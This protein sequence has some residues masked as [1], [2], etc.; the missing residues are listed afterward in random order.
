MIARLKTWFW[1]G[2]WSPLLELLL[3]AALGISLAHWTWVALT[4]RAVAA[5]ALG[6]HLDAQRAAPTVK[7]NLFGAAQGDKAAP[8]VVDASP[9][10][11]IKL[12]GIM[13]RGVVG[14]GRAIFALETGKPKTVEAGA[15]IVPGLE[16]REV[17]ADH[18]LVAR[19]GL[20]ERMRLDRRG[21]TRN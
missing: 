9:T 20:I 15:Q 19:S 5:S 3:I 17:H 11:R 2:G 12:L 18:V 6:M 7:R 1:R 8:A 16:L 4:P 13:S 21:A 10:S 14:S